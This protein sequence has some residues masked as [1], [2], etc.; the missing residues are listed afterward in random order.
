MRS[1]VQTGC[2]SFVHVAGQQRCSERIG[3]RNDDARHAADVGSQPGCIERTNV[4]SGGNEDFAAEMPA[5][6]FGGELILP[7]PAAPALIMAFMS[8]KALSGPP[9]P[10]SASATMGTS[11][12]RS[13]SPS[14]QAISSA[15]SSALLMRRTTEGTEFA[16]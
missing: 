13:P 9:K 12:S 3:A 2:V 14:D 8:S 1:P 6:L 4:L 16:G 5:L 10:A 15:R 11:Q 7:A